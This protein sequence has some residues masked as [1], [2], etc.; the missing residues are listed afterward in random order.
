MLF[1]FLLFIS[2]FFFL[3]CLRLPFHFNQISCVN[4]SKSRFTHKLNMVSGP[5]LVNKR[6]HMKKRHSIEEK[7]KNKTT[8]KKDIPMNENDPTEKKAQPYSN[9]QTIDKWKKK[10]SPPL[11]T[12]IE[13]TLTR[14]MSLYLVRYIFFI[15][16]LLFLLFLNRTM[17]QTNAI[18][19]TRANRAEQKKNKRERNN[20]R[21]NTPRWQQHDSQVKK[22][23]NDKR[24]NGI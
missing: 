4:R 1:F 16:F 13:N 23:H 8:T 10:N 7:K 2:F 6:G 18:N 17:K 19:P 20:I 11:Y 21:M 12:R 15:I 22:E 3:F 9:V 14:A 24:E 5:G